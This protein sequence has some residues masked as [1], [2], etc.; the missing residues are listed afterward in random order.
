MRLGDSGEW[1]ACLISA[2]PFASRS[3]TAAT[4]VD[5]SE[6]ANSRSDC[7]RSRPIV[8]VDLISRQEHL[9]VS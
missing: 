4:E 1:S 3:F 2:H 7:S 8:R 6:S 5:S 9:T